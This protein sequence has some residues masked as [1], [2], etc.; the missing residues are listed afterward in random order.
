MA[1][2]AAPAGPPGR[3]AVHDARGSPNG[4]RHH[5]AVHRHEGQL[6]RR[7]LPGRLHPPRPRAR[8]IT[9]R[10]RCSTST[11]AECIDCDACVEACPVDAT[12][13]EDDAPEQWE[14]F[15]EINRVYF[16][17]GHDGRRED[18]RRLPRQQGLAGR[19][20]L[21]AAGAL[22]VGPAVAAV[23]PMRGASRCRSGEGPGAPGRGR[24]RLDRPVGRPA[25]VLMAPPRRASTSS[26]RRTVAPPSGIRNRLQAS[27]Y[28]AT[29]GERP[30]LAHA[31]DEDRRTRAG[32]GR[33]AVDG[34]PGG[35][36]DVSLERRVVA[37]P[38]PNRE[39]REPIVN[40][41]VAT[42][43]TTAASTPGDVS[44]A[45]HRRPRPRVTGAIP[46]H[47]RPPE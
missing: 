43:L 32:Q 11:R 37:R 17:D 21:A 46:S 10:R 40:A 5:R 19:S 24:R 14:I 33:R 1:A 39:P 25:I 28:R 45:A 9:T 6:L 35:G 27:A 13:A 4:L 30:A 26:L 44:G 22:A 12:M 15:K 20:R 16:E 38:H 36:G 42:P 29:R 7:R 47:A 34:A 18:G 3:A 41:A 8:S 2:S 23:H 31:A